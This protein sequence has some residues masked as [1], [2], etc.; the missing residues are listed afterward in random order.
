LREGELGARYGG[1]EFALILPHTGA[2]EAMRVAQ[3]LRSR[4]HALAIAH[5][6]SSLGQIVTLSLGVATRV[7]SA[8]LSPASLIAAA[9][10]ALYSAK[11][12]GR[13]RA[14]FHNSIGPPPGHCP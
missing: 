14:I 10:D 5:K 9:D 4:I 12:L 6:A 1:E 13:D 8:N 2:E 7:P 3:T 11:A